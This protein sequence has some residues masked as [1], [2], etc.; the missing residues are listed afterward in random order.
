MKRLL[1]ISYDLN[2]APS[3]EYKALSDYLNSIADS[4]LMK[5]LESV[6]LIQTAMTAQQVS[7]GIKKVLTSEENGLRNGTRWVVAPIKL[8]ESTGWISESKIEWWRKAVKAG[9]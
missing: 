9:L 7:E 3:E 6:Y 1:M 4:G 2:K 5:P 8:S